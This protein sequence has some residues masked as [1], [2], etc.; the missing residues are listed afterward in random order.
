[1]GLGEM[2]LGEMG[3]HPVKHAV[4]VMDSTDQPDLQHALLTC[5]F[6]FDNCSVFLVHTVRKE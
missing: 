1:M 2:G 3:G 6:L 4:M 5:C